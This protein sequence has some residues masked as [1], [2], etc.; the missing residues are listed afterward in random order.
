MDDV[1]KK[2]PDSK[3]LRIHKSYLVNIKCIE[4]V[5]NYSILLNTGERLPV[6]K[7]RY[8]YVKDSFDT[9]ILNK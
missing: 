6:P 7:L 2:L 3:F 9:Y 4:E 1:E 8:R 5:K